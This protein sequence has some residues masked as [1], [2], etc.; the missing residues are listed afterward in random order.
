MARWSVGEAVTSIIV[1]AALTV[2]FSPSGKLFTYYTAMFLC[3]FSFATVE[4]YSDKQH[5]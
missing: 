5:T 4:N 1:G 3:V 2:C